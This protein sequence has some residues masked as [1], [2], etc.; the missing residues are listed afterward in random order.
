MLPYRCRVRNKSLKQRSPRGKG[1]LDPGSPRVQIC[2][3]SEF[4][5]RI[6]KS[7]DLPGIWVWTQDHQESRFARDLSLDPGSPRVQICQGS[8]FGSRITKSPDLPGIWVWTPGSPRVL[9]CQGSEFEPRDHQESR[10]ARDLSLDPG[11]TK[12]L[13]LPGIWVSQKS[14][15]KL[16]TKEP[17][18]NQ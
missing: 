1:S 13:N 18:F 3:G 8:V 16:K 17:S 4:G 10:F 5:P 15:R 14:T 7:P 9:I 6:S 2:Q 11:I 12:S